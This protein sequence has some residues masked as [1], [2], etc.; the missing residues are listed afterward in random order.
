MKNVILFLTATLC[1]GTLSAQEATDTFSY[2]EMLDL[3][4]LP[5]EE[6]GVD[7]LQRLNLVLPEGVEN[8][9][10]LLWIGGG[11]WSFVD[12]H[13]EMNLARKFAREGIAVA[14]VGHRLSKGLF[15]EPNRTH[16][17]KHPAH[18][19][20]IAAAFRWLYDHAEEYGYNQ[21]NLF[22]S[23]FSSGGHLSALL[24]M[25]GRYLAAH[26][27]TTR[28][29][30]AVLP[31]AGAYDINDYHSVFLNHENPQTRTL[32]D[33][34]VKDV[35]GDTEADFTH[36]SPTAYMDQ[37]S[38]PM[39]LTPSPF[40]QQLLIGQRLPLGHLFVRRAE[41]HPQ[42]DYFLLLLQEGAAV[43]LF[44]DLLQ[45][46]C[47]RSVELEFHDVNPVFG[48]D[49]GIDPTFGGAH[50]G[51]YQQTYAGKAQVQNGVEKGF[52]PL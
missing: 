28:H 7:S 16:G 31:V 9:P 46:G 23:G 24:A 26:G 5:P 15:K 1:I 51:L 29:I 36:A 30:K 43:A 34:H 35:F 25:D 33:T 41:T 50:F 8:P 13:V 21:E 11:A 42:G 38:T 40:Y 22:V 19:E 52:L 48:M 12:R 14:S 6:V 3:S 20:D 47:S 4:Y 27:L 17:V 44:P 32:A 37:L 10:I 18:I 2:R 39:L 49:D 45:G